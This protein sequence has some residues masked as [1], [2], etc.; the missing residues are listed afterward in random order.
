MTHRVTLA[1]L[2]LLL[3]SVRAPSLGHLQHVI[4]LKFLIVQCPCHGVQTGAVLCCCLVP[5]AKRPS[6]PCSFLAPSADKKC[7]PSLGQRIPQLCC[8]LPVCVSCLHRKPASSF[9]SPKLSRTPGFSGPQGRVGTLSCGQNVFSE[10]LFSD[11]FK[12]LVL[13]AALVRLGGFA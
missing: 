12:G 8:I 1:H 9:V 7:F 6:V 5:S 3:C 13:A 11:V 10:L 2:P 4:D